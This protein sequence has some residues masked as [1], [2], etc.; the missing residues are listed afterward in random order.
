M[1]RLPLIAPNPP[2][3]SEHLDALRRVEE[4]GVFSNNGPA[5]A[6]R[7]VMRDN[8]GVGLDCMRPSTT[9]ACTAAGGASCP[10]ATVPVAALISSS[11]IAIPVFPN[12][13]VVTLIMQCTVTASALL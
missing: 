12:G 3:L 7:A 13:G 2:R 8:P 5:A 11:G 4:S 6:S 1:K 10:A 9:A